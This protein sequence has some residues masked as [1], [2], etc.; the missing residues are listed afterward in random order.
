MYDQGTLTK[1]YDSLSARV[2]VTKF[3]HDDKKETIIKFI[4][5]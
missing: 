1:R 5:I 4:L 2:A 3:G